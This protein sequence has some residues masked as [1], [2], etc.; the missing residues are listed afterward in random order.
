M[1]PRKGRIRT[2]DK[3]EE[4]R[5]ADRGGSNQTRNGGSPQSVGVRR[6]S[7]SSSR[8]QSLSQQIKSPEAA[9]RD[10]IALS[11]RVSPRLRSE[12]NVVL[13]AL[14][15][16]P[17]SPQRFS[18]VCGRKRISAPPRGVFA[19]EDESGDERIKT[20]QTDQIIAVNRQLKARP[21]MNPVALQ[22]RDV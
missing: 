13:E 15:Q 17:E 22:R 11:T 16:I 10:R 20:H 7:R 8:Q 9:S 19:N 6:S 21:R 2:A 1:P 4:Y 12:E 18:Q 5:R 3:I 14:A